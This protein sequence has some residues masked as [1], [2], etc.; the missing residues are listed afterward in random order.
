MLQVK[1]YKI[2]K[3]EKKERQEQKINSML[4]FYDNFKQKRMESFQNL[5]YSPENLFSISAWDCKNFS[6]EVTFSRFLELQKF[7]C[8]LLL[9]VFINFIFFIKKH[10][11]QCMN[12]FKWH[13]EDDVMRRWY[14]KW[15]CEDKNQETATTKV[16]MWNQNLGNSVSQSAFTCA[17]LTIE[18]LE[19]GVKYVQS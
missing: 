14:I 2:R 15:T 1:K 12:F 16:W 18:T 5:T 11:L 8:W 9:D 7:D 13:C 10:T 6:K 17:K 4:L 3:E 19:Q